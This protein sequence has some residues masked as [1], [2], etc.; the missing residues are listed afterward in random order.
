MNTPQVPSFSDFVGGYPNARMP[1]EFLILTWAFEI[2][3][4]VKVRF[5]RPAGLEQEFRHTLRLPPSLG[6][7]L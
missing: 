4:K 1:A 5:F 2:L 6:V 3:L 7:A